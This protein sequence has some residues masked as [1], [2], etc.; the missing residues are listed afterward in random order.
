MQ[1]MNMIKHVVNLKYGLGLE[2]N[3]YRFSDERIKFERNPTMITRD[4]SHG[5][6]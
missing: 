2:L 5:K 1:K 3:N 6:E 4:E